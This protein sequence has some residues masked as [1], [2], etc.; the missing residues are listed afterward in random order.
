VSNKHLTADMFAFGKTKFFM[1]IGQIAKLEIIRQKVLYNSATKIQAI[2]RGHIQRLRYLNLLKMHYAAIKLQTFW[3]GYVQR[4]KFR[5]IRSIVLDIQSRFRA[6]IVRREYRRASFELCPFTYLF[7][8]ALRTFCKS[9]STLC[10]WLHG[11]T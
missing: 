5:K 1:K 6:N 4:E 3:R 7:L 2:W 8:D 11:P 9:H 10:A